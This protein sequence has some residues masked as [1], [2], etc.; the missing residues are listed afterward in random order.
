MIRLVQLPLESDKIKRFQVLC[1]EEI[2]GTLTGI[3]QE[4]WKFELNLEYE[5]SAPNYLKEINGQSF[6]SQNDA[7]KMLLKSE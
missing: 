6:L 3:D 5:S 7:E 1:N 4:I 2:I